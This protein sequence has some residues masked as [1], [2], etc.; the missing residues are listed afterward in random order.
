MRFHSTDAY[1]LPFGDLLIGKGLFAQGQSFFMT[2]TG[3]CL[4]PQNRSKDMDMQILLLL[5]IVI[6]ALPIIIMG[7]VASWRERHYEEQ[8]Q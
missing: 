5:G 1:F 2:D 4:L 6:V 3:A 8:A 7:C